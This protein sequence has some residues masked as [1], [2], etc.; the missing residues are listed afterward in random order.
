MCRWFPITRLVDVL[1]TRVFA[2]EVMEIELRRGRLNG[3]HVIPGS[4]VIDASGIV[5]S[6]CLH[7]HTAETSRKSST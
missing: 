6:F 2:K 1:N 3:S 4:R 5:L 7:R